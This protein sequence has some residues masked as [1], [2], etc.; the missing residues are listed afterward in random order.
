[1]TAKKI[2]DQM[3]SSLASGGMDRGAESGW[4]MD[5]IDSLPQGVRV[6]SGEDYSVLYLNGAATELWQ[7]SVSEVLMHSQDWLNWVMDGDRLRVLR[8]LQQLGSRETSQETLDSALDTTNSTLVS[9]RLRGRD[10]KVRLLEEKF[11]LLERDR[12]LAANRINAMILRV[13]ELEE[14]VAES[15]QLDL[16]LSSILDNI[17]IAIYVKDLEGRYLMVNRHWEF[18]RHLSTGDV[19]GKPDR[20]FFTPTEVARFREGDRLVI[21]QKAPITKEDEIY[22]ED[23]LHYLLNTKFPFC[24]SLG[25]VYAIGGVVTDIT[26]QKVVAANYQKLLQSQQITALEIQHIN[27]KLQSTQKIA[28]IG[29][30]DFN[31][32][33]GEVSWSEEVYRIFGVAPQEEPLSYP[34]QMQLVHPDDRSWYAASVERAIREGITYS[35]E[36]RIYNRQGELKFINARGDIL[37]DERGDIT[38]LYGTVVDITDR[39]LVELEIQEK[40]EFLSSIY[41]GIDQNIFVIDV[42][43]DG[44]F[45]SL[46]W[47]KRAAEDVGVSSEDGYGKTLGEVFGE[48][49]AALWEQDYQRCVDTGEVIRSEQFFLINGEEKWTITTLNPIRDINGRVYRIIGNSMD[50]TAQKLAERN[51]KQQEEFLR[52]IYDGVDMAVFVMDVTPENKFICS[53]FNAKSLKGLEV[54]LEQVQ[55][56][57]PVEAFG[58]EIGSVWQASY[59]ACVDAG[60]T[61]ST[62]ETFLRDGERRWHWTTLNPLRDDQGRIC[63][64][65]GTVIDVTR[66]RQAE[67][68]RQ[69]SEANYRQVAQR[70]ALINRLSMLMRNSLDVEQILSTTVTE[71]KS[72][73][74]V[75]ICSFA[76][77]RSLGE[78]LRDGSIATT[79]C[80][81]VVHRAKDPNDQSADDQK[82]SIYPVDACGIINQYTFRGEIYYIEDVEQLEDPVAQSMLRRFR[83]KSAVFMPIEALRGVGVVSCFWLES[84]PP[85]LSNSLSPSLENSDHPEECHQEFSQELWQGITAQLTAAINQAQLYKTSQRKAKELSH[86]LDDLTKAQTQLIQTEKMSSLGQMVAGIAHEIN[87]PVNFIYG[88]LTY[89]QEYTDKL[90]HLVELYQETFPDPPKVISEEMEDIELDY[91]QEDLPKIVKSMH[92]GATRIRE[93]VKSLR[94]FSRLDEAEMKAI[95]IHENIDSTLLILQN[96]LKAKS[97]HPPIQVV[98]EYG[99]LP[100]VECYAGQL[101]QV[102]MNL[103]ANAIDA[104]E[105]KDHQRSA[106]EMAQDPSKITIYTELLPGKNPQSPSTMGIRIQDNAL[107]MPQTVIDRIFDPFYTTKSVGKG[108]GLGLAISHQIIVDKHSGELVVTSEPGKG[109]TFLVKIPL[110]QSCRI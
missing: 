84:K 18:M 50:V 1:M 17:P 90:L 71:I 13:E 78:K 28:Q 64:L 58:E 31:C 104:L 94:T 87:N 65:I 2:L 11:W 63:H 91:L 82:L 48:E 85:S 55:G 89:I 110:K 81:E 33:T 109:T 79:H 30:W 4:C 102:F 15:A 14:T 25:E 105:E 32:H 72:Q 10:G 54:T 6:L 24:N 7:N 52:M 77:Y 23:G 99:E 95:D 61:I 46:G 12:G 66:V 36:F 26:E 43:L 29:S 3:P 59:Q 39:K 107:G 62:E 80:W 100:P 9:Y 92:L 35:C 88:N 16:F 53:G 21:S 93:I 108:T 37:R 73:L 20:E 40:A 41:D 8:C 83:A 19:L 45:R 60:T 22:Q 106:A 67:L 70:E 44:K 69:A 51:L 38:G 103:L 76:W 68:E 5:L 97:D 57:T 96:R 86:A 74:Q 47:N 75:D 49:V 56:K 27:L 98:K 34:A 42:G 101:N